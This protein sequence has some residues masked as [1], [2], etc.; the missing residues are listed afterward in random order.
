MVGRE[1]EDFT[2]NIQKRPIIH[3][4]AIGRRE[5]LSLCGQII[6]GRKA[7]YSTFG[8]ENDRSLIKRF[9]GLVLRVRIFVWLRL[10]ITFIAVAIR[11]VKWSTAVERLPF[12]F[13]IGP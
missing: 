11:G 8:E 9:I 2:K 6:S 3:R 7:T 12:W 4:R 5:S 10:I 13:Q 1:F